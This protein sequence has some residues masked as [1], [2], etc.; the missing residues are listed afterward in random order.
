MQHDTTTAIDHLL[1]SNLK[2]YALKELFPFKT[3]KLVPLHA[4]FNENNIPVYYSHLLKNINDVITCEF[5]I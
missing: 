5:S 4:N 2:L 3:G 1:I